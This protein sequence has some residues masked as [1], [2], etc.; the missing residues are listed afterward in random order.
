[1]KI[2]FGLHVSGMLGAVDLYFVQKTNLRRLTSKKSEDL[3]YTL[4]EAL[5][6]TIPGVSAASKTN[7]L[8]EIRA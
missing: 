2:R 3:N 8:L 6:R 4:T 7:I 1:M 5:N